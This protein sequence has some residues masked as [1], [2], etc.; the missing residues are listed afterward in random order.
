[1]SDIEFAILKLLEGRTKGSALSRDRLVYEVNLLMDQIDKVGDRAIREAIE[2]LRQT[3]ERGARIMSS[4]GWQGYWML[5]SYDEFGDFYREQR[6]R[7]LQMM[8]GLRKQRD[9]LG[10]NV[11]VA[12]R[13]MFA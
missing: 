8:T 4:S 13:R 1:M 12:Q 9:L 10:Q 11:E 7:A 6:S 3:S 5:G 2:N